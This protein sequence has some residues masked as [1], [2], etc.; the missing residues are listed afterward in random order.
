MWVN[1]GL[2]WEDLKLK[3]LKWQNANLKNW[4]EKWWNLEGEFCILAS[5]I[6]ASDKTIFLSFRC[7]TRIQLDDQMV[8]WEN[9]V[10]REPKSRSYCFPLPPFI[11]KGEPRPIPGFPFLL[12]LNSFSHISPFLQRARS[13]LKGLSFVGWPTPFLVHPSKFPWSF[14]PSPFQCHHFILFG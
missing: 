9:E 7:M 6:I 10:A 14:S 13:I 3:G 11:Y 4:N 1:R 8:F 2:N 5:N 12:R